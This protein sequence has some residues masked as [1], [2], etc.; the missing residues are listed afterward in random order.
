MKQSLFSISSRTKGCPSFVQER[1]FSLSSCTTGCSACG[2]WPFRPLAGRVFCHPPEGHDAVAVAGFFCFTSGGGTSPATLASCLVFVF[3]SECI[4]FDSEC[5]CFSIANVVFF[6]SAHF[7]FNSKC[8][9]ISIA[10]EGAF[11]AVFS[12]SIARY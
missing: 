7:F 2:A 6:N 5:M 8:F 9:F 4:F 11:A 12:F 1:L 3:N 10:A